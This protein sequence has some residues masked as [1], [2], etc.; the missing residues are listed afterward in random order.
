MKTIYYKDLKLN[1]I[2]K[3][4]GKIAC[5]ITTFFGE[6]KKG[7]SYRDWGSEDYKTYEDDKLANFK[8]AIKCHETFDPG[9]PYDLFIVDNSSTDPAGNQYLDFLPY[10]VYKRA[11]SGFSFGG[12]EWFFDNYKKYDYYLFHEQDC[13]PTKDDW[14]KDIWDNFQDPNVGMLGNVIEMRGLWEELNHQAI[15]EQFKAV[16]TKRDTIYNLDGTFYFTSRELLERY[17][18]RVLDGKVETSTYNEILFAQPIMEAGFKIKGY[19]DWKL[20]GKRAMTYGI[21]KG[22]TG[23]KVTKRNVTPMVDTMCRKLSKEFKQYFYE[24]GLIETA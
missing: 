1:S 5:V 9:I 13:C 22:D 10:M 16:G 6:G 4:P 7:Y 12:Y 8:F 24:K 11:N 14:L 18:L 15:V 20:K 19:D 3:K 23:K 21:H 17:P 2:E